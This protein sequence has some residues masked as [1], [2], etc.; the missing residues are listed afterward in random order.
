[1]RRRA[2][3]GG[4]E[5]RSGLVEHYRDLIGRYGSESEVVQVGPWPSTLA[6]LVAGEA[7]EVSGWEI[8]QYVDVSVG[9]ANMYRRFHLSSDDSLVEV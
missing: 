4:A 2:A 1:M 8:S 3:A 5:A 6:A 7:V 9:P